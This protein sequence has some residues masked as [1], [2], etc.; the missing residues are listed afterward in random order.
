MVAG[1]GGELG[2]WRKAG[3]WGRGDEEQGGGRS[4]AEL[5]LSCPSYSRVQLVVPPMYHNTLIPA[6]EWGACSG[7]SCL[8]Q[9]APAEGPQEGT[10]FLSHYLSTPHHS[11]CSQGHVKVTKS[12]EG[13]M[14]WQAK[15]KL[16]TKNDWFLEPKEILD[17]AP[18]MG[19]P[20][21]LS[22]LWGR[23]FHPAALSR[24]GTPLHPPDHRTCYF[25]NDTHPKVSIIQ[26]R[27]TSKKR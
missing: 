17:A 23:I 8:G 15:L 14:V 5:C 20:L 26:S 10:D 25:P 9:F 18:H 21:P 22:T 16:D 3:R 1:R 13:I 11:A 7:P 24:C 2:A 19:F 27:I 4:P 6:P 12:T